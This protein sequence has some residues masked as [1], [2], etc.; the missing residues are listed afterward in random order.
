MGTTEEEAAALDRIHQEA[1]RRE[2]EAL[3][4]ADAARKAAEEAAKNQGNMVAAEPT[5]W[6]EVEAKSG[7]VTAI[8]GKLGIGKAGDLA[9]AKQLLDSERRPGTKP[10][11]SR[12]DGARSRPSS[13]FARPATPAVER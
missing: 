6:P 1:I 9:L 13:A 2:A 5:G 7:P 10:E 4:A 3:K 11:A 8:A 12:G